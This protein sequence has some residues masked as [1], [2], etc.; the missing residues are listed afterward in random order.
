[1]SK[2]STKKPAIHRTR[3]L[4][5]SI[6]LP[7]IIAIFAIVIIL[8]GAIIAF[9]II[10]KKNTAEPD[11]GSPETSVIEDGF[12]RQTESTDT[13]AE[14]GTESNTDPDTDQ[15]SHA[16]EP[17]TTE[18]ASDT[19]DSPYILKARELVSRMNSNQKI[20]QLFITTPETLVNEISAA[21][22]PFVSQVGQVT[23]DSY[24]QYPVGGFLITSLSREGKPASDLT[25]LKSLCSDLQKLDTSQTLLLCIDE[26]YLKE[27]N[28]SNSTS[29]GRTDT[30]SSG[31]DSSESTYT[32]DDDT[33]K[34]CELNVVLSDCRT[35]DST[36]ANEGRKIQPS[37][38]ITDVNNKIDVLNASGG[39]IADFSNIGQDG[40]GSYGSAAATCMV[41]RQSENNQALVVFEDG[42][43]SAADTAAELK[44]I[45][46]DI[47]DRMNPQNPETVIISRIPASAQIS[48][49]NGSTVQ[50]A[51]DASQDA[52]SLSPAVRSLLI[53]ADILL[54]ES[55]LT[56]AHQSVSDALASGVL[57]ESDIDDCVSRILAMKLKYFDTHLVKDILVETETD[58]QNETSIVPEPETDALSELTIQLTSEDNLTDAVS[59]PASGGN[60][61]TTIPNISDLS[62]DN[63]VS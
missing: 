40:N 58:L 17:E 19:Q 42:F 49:E 33:L 24:A 46:D 16:P 36:A 26:D 51:A 25:M 41:Y 54:V 21:D 30:A 61:S 50:T 12:S 8:A 56:E 60:N 55:G 22:V 59:L 1:M 13:A 34:I 53:G 23:K 35:S 47:R 11:S 5:R 44:A 43:Y 6:S 62:S 63:P 4:K 28:L 20:C 37:V 39:F 3:R 2:N 57:T 27:L 9:Q 10:N 14:R 38:Q 48:A 52:E 31:S 15:T 18:G 45:R 29:S 32:I 7:V